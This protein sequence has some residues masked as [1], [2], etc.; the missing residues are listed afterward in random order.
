M[1]TPFSPI[2]GVGDGLS[3][4]VARR[5]HRAGHRLA[6]AARDTAGLAD[7]AA[8]VEAATHACDASDTDAVRT[9]SVAL[10]ERL[11]V[12]CRVDIDG[13]IGDPVREATPERP[14]SRPDP[15][16]VA[17]ACL[18]PIEQHRSTCS[19]ELALRPRTESF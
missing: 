19:S 9:L 11:D 18:G 7:L 3:A 5:L 14:D 6:L 2:V 13:A 15:V 1:S 17:D 4:S 12:V 8:S 16:G 10:D